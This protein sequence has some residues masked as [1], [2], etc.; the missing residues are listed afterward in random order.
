[1]SLDE[2]EKHY[3]D[4]MSDALNKLQRVTLLSSNLQ[5]SLEEISVSLQKLNQ[6]TEEFI[7]YQRQNS[8]ESAPES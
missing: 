6:T 1:M 2:F 8:D 5:E 4:S 3:R 7:N